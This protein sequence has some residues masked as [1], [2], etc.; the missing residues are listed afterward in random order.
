MFHTVCVTKWCGGWESIKCPRCDSVGLFFDCQSY[1]EQIDMLNDIYIP[2]T[3][4]DTI[5][6]NNVGCYDNIDA[7]TA[8]VDGGGA[9]DGDDD[10]DD[11]GDD[12]NNNDDGDNNDE[13]NN[14]N[15]NY[16]GNPTYD[17]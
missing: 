7:S 14:N 1:K 10:D 6:G 5:K 9:G 16:D 4:R 17:D 3:Q 2:N 13:N 12:N 8:I 15:D 11:V